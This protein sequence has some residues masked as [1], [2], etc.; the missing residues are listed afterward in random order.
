VNDKCEDL[1]ARRNVEVAA[2][3]GKDQVDCLGYIVHRNLAPY[4]F[5]D[6][7]LWCERTTCFYCFPLYG[8]KPP[9]PEHVLKAH[10]E[11]LEL[12]SP[13]LERAIKDWRE[14]FGRESTP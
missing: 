3:A 10:G 11:W 7:S 2:R 6:Y 12:Q 4:E 9:I 8:P 5:R 14:V 1:K 13:K